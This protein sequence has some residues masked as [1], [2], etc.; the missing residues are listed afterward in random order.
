MYLRSTLQVSF[1]VIKNHVL[2]A[3][4]MMDMLWH[5]T[6]IGQCLITGHILSIPIV[7]N[8]ETEQLPGSV[9]CFELAK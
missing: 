7:E 8:L 5:I 1:P 3:M 6:E 4:F 2:I 9:P